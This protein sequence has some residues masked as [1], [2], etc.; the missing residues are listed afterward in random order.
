MVFSGHV[1]V[2]IVYLCCFQA[3]S[4][5]LRAATGVQEQESVLAAIKV[6]SDS[7]SDSLASQLINFLL[8]ADEG[9][10]KDPKYLF[11]LYMSREMYKEAAK[12]ALI[13]SGQEQKAGSYRCVH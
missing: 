9:L 5:L 10:P 4:L 1:A 12:T 3:M 7:N 8:G 6:V 11:Q 13:V 2:I